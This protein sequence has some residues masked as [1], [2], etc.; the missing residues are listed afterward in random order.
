MELPISTSLKAL[1]VM[2][3]AET[4]VAEFYS[5]CSERFTGHTQFWS[6]LAKEEFGHAEVIRKLIQLVRI[7]PAQFTAGKS[8][9]LE[10]V[11]AFVART[12]SNI[13]S[14]RRGD[15][16]EDKALLIA[17]HIENTVI[18]AQYADVVSTENEEYKALLDQVVAD[19]LR[20]KES[21][22]GKMRA[23]KEAQK[24]PEKPS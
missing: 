7:Q 13:E 1:D 11:K 9:P 10:A 20:H 12:R 17:Y 6:S 18:E 19:T 14:M 16:P 4:T 2:V 15:L 22:L 24:A 21:V 3:E 5:L 23:L 8:T